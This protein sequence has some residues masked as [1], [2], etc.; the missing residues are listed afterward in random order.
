[1]EQESTFGLYEVLAILG[2]LAW[3]PQVISWIGNW[4]SKPILTVI[5]DKELEIGY[6]SFGPIVNIRLAFLSEKKKS[7]IKSID[8]ELT[9]EKNDTQKFS[10]DWFEET[11]YHMDVPDTGLFPTKKNQKAIAINIDKDQLVE[12]KIGFQQNSF[13][14]ENKQLLQNTTEEFLNLFNAGKDTTE[15]KSRKCYNDLLDYY[16]NSFNWK[17]GTYNAKIVINISEKKI[18]FEHKVSFRLTSLDIKSLEKNIDRCKL[19]V[20]KEY[21]NRDLELEETWAWIYPQELTRN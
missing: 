8:I 10:W 13:K 9:H 7:L 6:S 14:S 1:M 21:I 5:S 17:V 20:E 12:K 18:S 15:I 2:A 3:L 4:L 19:L 11:L 16:K